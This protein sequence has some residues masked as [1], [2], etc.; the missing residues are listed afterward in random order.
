MKCSDQER[1][2]IQARLNG[3]RTDYRGFEES[4]KDKPNRSGYAQTPERSPAHVE[5]YVEWELSQQ[6]AL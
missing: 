4:S 6:T 5:W 2:E 1:D 3:I